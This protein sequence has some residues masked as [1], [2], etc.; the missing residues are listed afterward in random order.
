MGRG[1]AGKIALVTGV[2]K[3][4]VDA[5]IARIAR[6]LPGSSVDG[7]VVRSIVVTFTPRRADRA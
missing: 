1:I 4:L 6:D 7:G 3:A 5:A 2:D